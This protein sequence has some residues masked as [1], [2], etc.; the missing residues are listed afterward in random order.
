ML[1]NS[2]ELHSCEANI[3]KKQWDSAHCAV[4][5]FNIQYQ[6]KGKPDH[7]FCRFHSLNPAINIVM[8]LCLLETYL[9]HSYISCLWIYSAFSAINMSNI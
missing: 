3:C 6:I 2:M 9:C 8:V 5:Q 1:S 7:S 4:K